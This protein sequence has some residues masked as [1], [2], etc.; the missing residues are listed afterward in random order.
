MKHGFAC[1]M[2][3]GV[4]GGLTGM[5]P[6]KDKVASSLYYPL[7][8]GN[9]W[10]YKI[11]GQDQPFTVKVANHEQVGEVWC[12]RLESSVGGK[13]V[14]TEDVAV[15]KDG[16]YRYTMAGRK[17][18]PPIR[19]LKLPFKK[20]DSW[21][22][23]SMIGDEKLSVEYTAGEEEV[24]VAAGKYKAISTATNEFEAGNQKIQ[25]TIWYAKNVGMI[26]TQMKIGGRT[27]VLELQKFEA[28]K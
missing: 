15:Q 8:V 24:E 3:L 20:G 25:A 14:A 2:A 4:V 12:A 23:N 6:G 1:A 9:T 16:I 11:V 19:F 5:A 13:V 27:S 17:A 10:T 26:K 18:D 28:G 21:K 22:V 7:K